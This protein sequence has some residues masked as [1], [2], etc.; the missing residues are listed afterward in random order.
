MKTYRLPISVTAL[1]VLLTIGGAWL[2]ARPQTQHLSS[3][4]PSL[5]AAIAIGTAV[6]TPGTVAVSTTTTL[7]VTI[8]VT[9]SSLIANGVNLI[10]VNA[11]GT[12]SIILGV[13]HDDGKNGDATA[14]DG[15][16]T[17][18]VPVHPPT[19]GQLQFQVSA[20]FRGALNRVLSNVMVV[21]VWNA[22]TN[23]Q[24][25]FSFLYP[26]TW[27]VT[28]TSTN[29]KT[30]SN[31]PLSSLNVDNMQNE[32]VVRLTLHANANPALL[33]IDQWFNN[34]SSNGFDN[35]PLSV[36]TPTIAGRQSIEL[37]QV[38]V[39]EFFSLFVADSADVLEV[40]YPLAAPQFIVQYQALIGSLQFSK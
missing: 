24:F 14:G 16:Y 8:Q 4:A 15:V 13:M 39:G 20:A 29:R 17:L 36:S 12:Q 1:F 23:S 9:N 2:Y 21:N 3:E 34:Y 26:P 28:N 37:D 5:S 10:Q 18:L 30:I 27:I 6:V 11:S 7:T 35:P 33:P 32:A 38:D 31:G 22:F 25:T 40:Y 19:T